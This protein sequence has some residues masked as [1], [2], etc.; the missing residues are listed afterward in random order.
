MTVA[1][2]SH[3]GLTVSRIQGSS[4]SATA[5]AQTVRK[6]C[7]HIRAAVHDPVVI[8]AARRA[9]AA[10][11]ADS[12][13]ARLAV[14]VFMAVKHTVRF[15]H[16]DVLIRALLNE[17]NQLELLISPPVLLRMRQPAGDC[18]DFVMLCCA[19]LAV[20]GIPARIITICSDPGDPRRFSH[21]YCEALCQD[22]NLWLNIDAANG[23]YPGWEVPPGRRYRRVTWDLAGNVVADVEQLPR[24]MPGARAAAGIGD[25]ATPPAPI[26]PAPVN[27]SFIDGL[28]WW[29]DAAGQ[30][31]STAALL[32]VPINAVSLTFGSSNLMGVHSN[33]TPAFRAGVALPIVAAAWLLFK[34][35]KR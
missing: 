26:D 9:A 31:Q 17:S 5:T 19:M 16:D 29:K 21:V 2:S 18:D 15:V 20:L 35:G 24:L 3:S 32:F 13:P 33:I 11:G 34:N 8:Q 1:D 6:M 10:A 23:D 28:K 12:S 30:I 25:I 27:L 14:A 22:E 7:E 4:D